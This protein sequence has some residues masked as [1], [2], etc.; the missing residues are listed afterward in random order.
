M[1]PD[2]L[3]IY[4]YLKKNCWVVDIGKTGVNLVFVQK[5][6]IIGHIPF[7]STFVQ[8]KAFNP[9]NMSPKK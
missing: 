9:D 8:P 6:L 1:I 2:K 7:S 3:N 4:L 5:P